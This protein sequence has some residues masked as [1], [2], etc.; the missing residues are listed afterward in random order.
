VADEDMILCLL[1]GQLHSLL[2]TMTRGDS[3]VIRLEMAR[4]MTS[5][6]CR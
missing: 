6:T 4:C 1:Q 2:Q 3:G 5:T